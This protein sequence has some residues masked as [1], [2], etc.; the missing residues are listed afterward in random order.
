MYEDV[1]DSH[2][3]AYSYKYSIIHAHECDCVCV[4]TGVLA[5]ACVGVCVFASQ[6]AVQRDEVLKPLPLVCDSKTTCGPKR[7]HSQT[8][9]TLHHP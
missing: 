3:C 1:R 4:C 8:A 7:C 2:V 5:C 9:P 6:P